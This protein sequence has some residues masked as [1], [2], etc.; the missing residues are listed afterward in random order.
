[1]NDDDDLVSLAASLD[2]VVRSLKGP[3]A[4]AVAGVF[5]SW[6]EAVGP[7]VAAHARPLSFD[8]G[9]LVVEVDDPAWATQLRY[10]ESD[11]RERLAGVSGGFQLVSIEV[12]VRPR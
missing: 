4:R 2:A 3:G 9:R 7:Q 11:L 5:A 1:M 10:L 12:R 6:E 8:G